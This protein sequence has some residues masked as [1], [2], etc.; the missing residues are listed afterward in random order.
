MCGIALNF[1]LRNAA[2]RLVLDSIQHRGPDGRGE[3]RSNDGR[4]WMGHTRLAILELSS[5]GAQPMVDPRTQNATAFNGE[6]YN[7]FAPRQELAAQGHGPWIG[8]SDTET[9]LG[10]YRFWD[11]DMLE[12]LKGMF[13]FAIYDDRRR[14][15]LL[16]RDRL[17]IKPLYYKAT[18]GCFQ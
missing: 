1:Q 16:A 4:P 12:R 11:R 9:L 10:A 2:E 15:L 17:G 13:A 8:S 18:D 14:E 5:A 6:I 3:W 7:N